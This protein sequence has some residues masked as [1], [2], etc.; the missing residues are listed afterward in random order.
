M[1]ELSNALALTPLLKKLVHSLEMLG[2]ETLS[3]SEEESDSDQP[4]TE[5]E[6]ESDSDQ[7]LTESEEEDDRVPLL[8]DC[9][10]DEEELYDLLEECEAALTLDGYRVGIKDGFFFII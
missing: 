10:P 8:E 5:S 9:S 4:L 2:L 7:P 1:D 6:E 3:E